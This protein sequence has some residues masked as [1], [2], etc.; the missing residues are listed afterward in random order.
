MPGQ[1]NLLTID[2]LAFICTHCVVRLDLAIAARRLPL[3]WEEGR[4]AN[5]YL[6]V[7]YSTTPL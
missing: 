6:S 1:L 3:G 2:S 7:G 5:A 4:G